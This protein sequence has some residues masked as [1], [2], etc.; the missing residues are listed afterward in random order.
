MSN[1]TYMQTKRIA[2]QAAGKVLK[3][4]NTN[5]A[6]AS[7]SVLSEA[8]QAAYDSLA[9]LGSAVDANEIANDIT[10]AASSSRNQYHEAN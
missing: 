10:W 3:A 9:P 4:N 8:F 1:L 2:Y 6:N 5:I 7:V